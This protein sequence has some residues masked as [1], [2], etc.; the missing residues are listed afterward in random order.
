MLPRN[1]PIA[2]WTTTLKVYATPRLS[3]EKPVDV[4]P[5][6]TS[7]TAPPGVAVIV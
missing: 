4:E 5:A 2:L 1:A 7:T 3:P 6:G